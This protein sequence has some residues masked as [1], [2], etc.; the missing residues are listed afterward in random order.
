[1]GIYE[2]LGVRRSSTRRRRRRSSAVADGGIGARRDAGC[3]AI[4]HQP[5]RV[6]R[7]GGERIAELT[8]NEAAAVT[9]GAAAGLLVAAG[10]CIVRDEYRSRHRLP[11]LSGFQHTEFISWESQRNGFLMSIRETGATLSRSARRNGSPI[12]DLRPHRGDHLVRRHRVRRGALP[13]A[14]HRAHR[15]SQCV[16]VIVDAADQVPPVANLW[17]FTRDMGADLAVFSGG[18]GLGGPQSSG[19]VLGRADLIRSCRA[20]GGP[21]QSIGRPAKV[22][23]E[24]LAGLLAAVETAVTKDEAAELSGSATPSTGGTRQLASS[25]D[26]H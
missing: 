24:E 11:D 13:L 16:P 3:G 26:D 10:A 17:K 25:R 22:G 19:L 14:G 21:Y 12:S 9:C 15:Q 5:D 6:S 4:V 23:K 18:K 20:N 7:P 2:R 8:N 1:M